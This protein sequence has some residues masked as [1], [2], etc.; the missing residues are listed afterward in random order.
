MAQIRK[1]EKEKK[2]RRLEN[3][4][5]LKG[6]G[7][8]THAAKQALHQAS[9]NLDEALKVSALTLSSGP[10]SLDHSLLLRGS[11]PAPAYHLNLG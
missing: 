7:Y 8:S 11:S 2:K 5:N 4:N 3:I 9:G 1:E 10:V 6:M